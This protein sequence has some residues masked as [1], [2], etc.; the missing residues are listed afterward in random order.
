MLEYGFFSS[1]FCTFSSKNSKRGKTGKQ[2]A[3][4]TT[5]LNLNSLVVHKQAA[6]PQSA[7]LSVAKRNSSLAFRSEKPRVQLNPPKTFQ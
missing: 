4:L 3:F 6:S 5:T 7:Q 1:Q 2:E